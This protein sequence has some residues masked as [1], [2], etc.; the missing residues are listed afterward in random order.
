MDPKHNLA[1]QARISALILA[2][3]DRFP[4]L[5]K[6]PLPETSVMLVYAEQL[7][8]LSQAYCDWIKKGGFPS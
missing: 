7:A 8:E 1:E 6:M 4:D 2:I 3:T 5:P